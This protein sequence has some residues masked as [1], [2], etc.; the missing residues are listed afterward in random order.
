MTLKIL[1]RGY[2]KLL[3]GILR[4]DKVHVLIGIQGREASKKHPKAEGLTVAEVGS[5]H[6]F[7]AGVPRR[8]FL[9]DWFD[10]NRRNLSKRMVNIAKRV[11]NPRSKLTSKKGLGIFGAVAVG[12]IQARISKGIF[13]PL[14]QK[15]LDA[16]F[17][18]KKSKKTKL[19]TIMVVKK[20]RKK[21]T[22]LI[23]TGQLRSSITWKVDE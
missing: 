14:S 20:G 3:K 4:D 15:T 10:E 23:D 8:S 6:E 2:K 21:A 11:A 12:E 9:R 19:G 13:P 1:D 18:P 22:P 16:R 17:G 7:G 5:I